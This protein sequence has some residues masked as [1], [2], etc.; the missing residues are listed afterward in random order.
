MD[1]TIR[2]SPSSDL[3]FARLNYRGLAEWS[4]DWWRSVWFFMQATMRNRCWKWLKAREDQTL[5][6][7]PI[8]WWRSVWFFMQA[9][10]RNRGWKW[11]K[12]REDQTLAEWSI[13]WWRSVWFFMQATMRNR[14]WSDLKLEKTRH[15]LNDRSIDGGVFGF[16]CKPL[17]ETGVEVT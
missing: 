5:A 13:D 2:A 17:W 11:L 7:W 3:V 14:C 8:D 1:L 4:I 12:A 6:E 16:L 15:W 10:M 9:T